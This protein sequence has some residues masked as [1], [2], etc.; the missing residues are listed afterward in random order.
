MVA[1]KAITPGETFGRLTV[2]AEIDRHRRGRRAECRCVCG[3]VTRVLVTRLR[4]GHTQS[5]GCLQRERVRAANV[6]HEQTRHPL[7]RV[8]A[9]MKTRCSNPRVRGFANYGGRGITVCDRW[10]DSFAAF[11]ADM[12]ERPSSAHTIERRDNNAGYSAE[13]CYWATRQ[14]Q[15]TNKRRTRWITHDGVTLTA[16]EWDRRLGLHQGCVRQRL[17]VYHWSIERALTTLNKG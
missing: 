2:L 13:N 9:A 14:E 12:G 8:W 10:R 7:Y 17:F 6:T 5:C 11:F 16:P 3:T 1:R 15:S 4:D